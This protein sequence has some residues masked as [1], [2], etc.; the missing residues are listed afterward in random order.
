M[1]KGDK[2]LGFTGA[3]SQDHLF[4]NLSD[5]SG[6]FFLSVEVAASSLRSVN[7]VQ[8]GKLC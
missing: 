3:S 5:I 1:G 8:I 6:S 2:A 7:C 4:M